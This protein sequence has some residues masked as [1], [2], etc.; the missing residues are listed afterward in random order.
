MPTKTITVR[1]FQSQ[2]DLFVKM[3]AHRA[4]FPTNASD[5]LKCTYAIGIAI[6]CIQDQLKEMRGE[7]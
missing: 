7:K 5:S 6:T 4:V 1:M 2:W 3:L